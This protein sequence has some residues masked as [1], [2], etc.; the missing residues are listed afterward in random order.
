MNHLQSCVLSKHF[1]R[2]ISYI[3]LIPTYIKSRWSF[4]YPYLLGS[5]LA[6]GGFFWN[7]SHVTNFV[8]LYRTCVNKMT[9]ASTIMTCLVLI[10]WL[11]NFNKVVLQ[12]FLVLFG[13][14]PRPLLLKTH[15]WLA[16]IVSKI[17]EPC[18][19][20]ACM[21]FNLSHLFF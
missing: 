18:V 1:L 12:T 6:S 15:L 17:L 14:I 7:P 5:F 3:P 2:T 4:W 20:F 11:F 9:I 16:S 8:L 13:L 21:V 19:N 10:I